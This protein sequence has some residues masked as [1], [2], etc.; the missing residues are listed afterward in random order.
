MTIGE[1]YWYKPYFF[2]NKSQNDW[3]HV[4]M[5]NIGNYEMHKG[6]EGEDD[7][8]WTAIRPEN[9]KNYETVTNLKEEYPEKFI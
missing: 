1:I 5:T 4:G 7:F 3:K 2:E 8:K 6:I 9:I